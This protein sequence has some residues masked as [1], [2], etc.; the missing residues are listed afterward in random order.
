MTETSAKTREGIDKL[1]SLYVPV[2]CN[3]RRVATLPHRSS[4]P[5]CLP[6]IQVTE[7]SAKT[8]EGIDKLFE[9]VAFRMLNKVERCLCRVNFWEFVDFWTDPS[10][11]KG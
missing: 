3:P 6:I 1:S 4:Q 11:T 7:T 2:T 9:R 8:R 5:S 10:H